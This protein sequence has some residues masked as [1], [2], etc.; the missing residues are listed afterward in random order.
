ML[1]PTITPVSSKQSLTAKLSSWAYDSGSTKQPSWQ[2]NATLF[3]RPNS[4]VSIYF[5]TPNLMSYLDHV[6]D[7][8]FL[9][10]PAPL[11]NVSDSPIYGPAYP[12]TILGCVEDQELCNPFPPE[13]A[14]APASPSAL[15]HP[16]LGT[17][18][19]PPP[20][21]PPP[22][23]QCQPFTRATR[24]DPLFTAL[25][26]NPAQRATVARLRVEL[27]TN[28]LQYL[29]LMLPQSPLLASR[30][31]VVGTQYARLPRDQWRAEVA[32]WFGIS[33]ALL[34]GAFLEFATGPAPVA[35]DS[36]DPD[37]E[38]M[39]RL[40]EPIEDDAVREGCK[41][42]RIGIGGAAGVRNFDLA[43]LVGV[44]VPGMGIVV[45]G[46]T[47]DTVVGWCQR[48]MERGLRRGKQWGSDGMFQL[49]RLAAEA[50]G[51]GGWEDVDS[52]VPT[53]D[54]WLES[55]SS[56]VHDPAGEKLSR[57]GGV[58]AKA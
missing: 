57:S 46:L 45:L 8:L 50:R 49:G 48:R 10:A 4:F 32:R 5:L 39:R 30:G 42:Q 52:S 20:P 36:A 17:I 55:G 33:M 28:D 9:T 11:Q 13:A 18:D 44:V 12:V 25:H 22:P 3:N 16:R 31:A 26:L 38:G 1:Q 19:A 29:S 35:G 43:A 40:V 47:L 2:P 34:Q 7:P 23:R 54:E 6:Y 58:E 56:D 41:S 51:I 21:P 15:P 27:L 53:T 14:P 24:D 37:G